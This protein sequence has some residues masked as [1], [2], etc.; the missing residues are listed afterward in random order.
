MC[1]SCRH[2]AG[3]LLGTTSDL[4]SFSFLLFDVMNTI[5][6]CS[7]MSCEDNQQ[8]AIFYLIFVIFVMHKDERC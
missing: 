2:L 5:Q 7:V 8:I 6:T 3:P 1:F 4:V